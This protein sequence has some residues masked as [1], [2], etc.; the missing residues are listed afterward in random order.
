[1]KRFI[2]FL[3]VFLSLTLVFSFAG[4]FK[5]PKKLVVRQAFMEK[6]PG[7]F[8]PIEYLNKQRETVGWLMA[9]AAP[10]SPEAIVSISISAEDL[11]AVENNECQT[12]GDSRSATR[13]IKVGLTK[14]VDIDVKLS[15]LHTGALS[16]T[17][18]LRSNGMVRATG[19]GGFVWTAA[20][21]SLRAVALRVHFSNFSLPEGAALYVYN[22]DD[23]A[24]GPYTGLGPNND[25]DFWS[26]TVSG[27]IAYIQ[28][29]FNGKPTAADLQNSGF[30]IKGIAHL[31]PKFLLPF[32]KDNA[33]TPEVLSGANAFCSFNEPCVEDASCH[34]NSA[35]SVAKDAVAH[36]QWISGAWIYICSGGLVAD[37]DTSTQIPYF[38]TA[39]HC[40]S[41]NKDA[42]SLECFF[43]FAT[44]N[45]G[46]ACYDPVGVT[47]R[48]LGSSVVSTG[49]NADYTL[50][51]LAEPAPAGSAFLG[52]NSTPVAFSNG[53]DLY[54]ISHPSG[55]PQAFSHHRVDTSAGTC[56]GW[57]RG[58]RIYSR[59][60][61]GATEGGSSG[62]P[63]VNSSGQ[64]VGQLSGACG[65]NV[66]ET[67]DS[68]SNATVD[69]AFAAYYAEVAQWLDNGGG[70]GGSEMHIDSITLSTKKK[71]PKTDLT[72]VVT[73]L[74][75]NGDPVSGAVVSGTFTGYGSASGTTGANGQATVK[76]SVNGNITSFEF[77]V[78]D[79]THSSY[80]YNSS[81]NVVTCASI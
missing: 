40:L 7:T 60:I 24:F 8:N 23:E 49:R 50:L 30:S 76:L 26:N 12:C 6:A 29:R 32:F 78:D 13:R 34:N 28:L 43:Q 63:V 14:P 81:A 35:V 38:I 18:A 41:R 74:D 48:T 51:E 15:H 54:R 19:D 73:I 4:D 75:E 39:N 71:G 2:T 59:D 21:E 62:S 79:V 27:P 5:P 46:G 11:A 16:G 64:L 61:V 22:S 55:A 58:D 70:S 77:C 17:A 72:A 45:C 47:P 3:T 44:S 37:K 10:L 67:C 53:T 66:N 68:E 69:G 25:G 42:G 57:P 65:T 1:M 52:W 33:G 80:T 36:M 56:S 9:E 31:T 20:A